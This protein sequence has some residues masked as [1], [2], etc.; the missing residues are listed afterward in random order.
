MATAKGYKM[1]RIKDGKLFPLY[2]L[3]N[4]ETPMNVWI[5]AEEG[6]MVDGKV[7]S[8]LGKL[9]YRPGWHIAEIPNSPWIGKKTGSGE[10]IRRKDCV[11]CEV[12]YHTD[13]N[14]QSEARENGWKA[15][16]WAVQRAY[17]KHI[18]WD[19]YYKF[20]TNT[21]GD[22]W[23]ISGEIKVNQILSN[24][25]VNRICLENGVIPQRTE[26]EVIA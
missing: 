21:N 23:I 9:A 6:E 16:C 7:K 19:G 1:F 24:E 26:S 14:Y 18:P 13:K 3:S 11:W 2:V 10:L 8:K 15:G 25:E 5:D 12:E 20:R 4:K 17:L 22:V